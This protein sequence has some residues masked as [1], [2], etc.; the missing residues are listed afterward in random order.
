VLRQSLSEAGYV[1]GH[2][3]SIEYRWAYDAID[4]LPLLAADLVRRPVALIIASADPAAVA[5]KA[6]TTDIPIVFVGGGD[7]VKLG[8]VRSLN[9]PGNNVTG[10]TILNIEISPKRLQLLNELVP[11]TKVV[12]VLFG[13]APFSFEKQLSDFQRAARV[14]GL[15]LH[16]LQAGTTQDID[17]A[18]ETVVGRQIGAVAVAASAF[19]NNRSAQLGALAA[20]S[21]VPAI[22]QTREFTA[23]G[24]LISYGASLTDAYHLVG[25]YIGRIL[26]GEKPADLPVQQSAKIEMI[27]NLK[28]AKALGVTVPITLL[29]RADEVIE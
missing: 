11:Q 15:E 19:F 14:L 6:A 9:E 18:F 7:P 29:G 26:K 8:L 25:G 21:G 3:I 1:E 20:H 24:G 17:R 22:F 4:R 2:N 5:A 16:V 27:I 23:A 28:T 12:A 13:N 10:V